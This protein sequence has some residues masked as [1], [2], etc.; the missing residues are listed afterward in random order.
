VQN[1]TQHYRR[2]L[3]SPPGKKL[4]QDNN[5]FVVGAGLSLG[6]DSKMRL[7][8]LFGS[9]G[10]QAGWYAPQGWAQC[11]WRAL[12]NIYE[13]PLQILIFKRFFVQISVLF[14]LKYRQD[15]DRIIPK[16]VHQGRKHPLICPKP[17][18]F[19]ANYP[20]HR[21]GTFYCSQQQTGNGAVKHKKTSKTNFVV[22]SPESP[23]ERHER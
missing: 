1:G 23:K 9:C 11:P 21:S 2:A 14:E 19:D 6:G 12:G 4:L 18:G 15:L 10:W 3:I 13:P 22:V 16:K 17:A 20:N 5:R 8:D 7:V